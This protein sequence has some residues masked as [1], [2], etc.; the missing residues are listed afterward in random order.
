[1]TIERERHYRPPLVI[2]VACP[3]IRPSP[4]I[5]WLDDIGKPATTFE[6]L[7]PRRI[8]RF[9]E[10]IIYAYVS[11]LLCHEAG[12][13]LRAPRRGTVD[14]S[15]CATRAP[16]AEAGLAPGARPAFYLTAVPAH[17]T[18]HA[19]YFSLSALPRRRLMRECAD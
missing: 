10:R 9:C 19:A 8:C 16:R 5:A 4:G 17:F 13:E 12:R 11:R 6:R 1:M 7:P 3:P 15:H 18:P 14:H 2:F